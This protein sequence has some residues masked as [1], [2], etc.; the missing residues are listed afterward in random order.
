MNKQKAI[1]IVKAM[2]LTSIVNAT[3]VPHKATPKHVVWKDKSNSNQR[4]K[5][6]MVGSCDS[7]R[8]YMNRNLI[9]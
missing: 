3:V 8:K 4:H 2:N 7:L 1:K 6:V 5:H 9:G